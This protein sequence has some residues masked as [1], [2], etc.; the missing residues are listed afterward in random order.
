MAA[1]GLVSAVAV[2]GT[3][4]GAAGA[5]SS[6]FATLPPGSVGAGPL[7]TAAGA[8]GGWPRAR[9]AAAIPFTRTG[10][11]NRFDTAA[12]IAER[13]YTIS[14]SVILADGEGAADALSAGYLA[15][16]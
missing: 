10:G 6:G 7:A 4:A 5:S 9:A 13:A 11:V 15:G 8:G 12:K 1:A 16:V 2:V 3:A 14:D